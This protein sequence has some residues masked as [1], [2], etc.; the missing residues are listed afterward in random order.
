[1]GFKSKK[2]LLRLSFIIICLYLGTSIHTKYH[3][4]RSEI[5]YS[6]IPSR[7][8]KKNLKHYAE[9]ENLRLDNSNANAELCAQGRLSPADY[10]LQKLIKTKNK[11]SCAWWEEVSSYF[12]FSTKYHSS[13]YL[14]LAQRPCKSKPKLLMKEFPEPLC[15]KVSHLHSSNVLLCDS[16]NVVE[17]NTG[18][19]QRLW[20]QQVG[21]WEIFRQTY[22][23]SKGHRHENGNTLCRFS[24]SLKSKRLLEYGSGI[25]PFSTYVLTNCPKNI[26]SVSI[27]D[28][29]AEHYFFALWSLRYKLDFFVGTSAELRGYEIIGE[30]QIIFPK[31]SFDIIIVITVFE[32]L[33]NPFD[34]AQML[35]KSL[36]IG[37]LIYEDFCA[38]ELRSGEKIE[39]VSK[40]SSDPNLG[41]ARTERGKT[42]ALFQERCSLLF[43]NHD[44][45]S[46]RLW[47]C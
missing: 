27:V 21:V 18:I 2:R 24:D 4:S 12:Q 40:D 33:P 46:K 28:I 14:K 45:C 42:V 8:R 34:V 15:T 5:E 6:V 20:Y 44:E 3:H 23:N 25:A 31:N 38:P 30:E 32:H 35:L 26:N 11:E 39:N 37:G 13:Y 22:Y 36:D 47:K 7:A 17:R 41:I 19:L 43:G 9:V 16:W 1:M 29:P 10:C